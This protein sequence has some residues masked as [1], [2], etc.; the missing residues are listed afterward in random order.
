[1]TDSTLNSKRIAR[2]SIYMA[3]R[4]VFVLGLT[5]Y[6]TRIILRVLGVE[7]YGIYNVVCGFV[8]MLAFLSTSMSNGIQRFYNFEY[9][10]NGIAGATKVYNTAIIIQILLS[11]IIVI[12]A[13]SFGLWYL[14]N[15]MVIP[16]ERFSAA[17]IIFQCSIINFVFML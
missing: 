6:T 3:I 15:K 13:E 7:D 12:L 10:K 5:L 16:I 1:M 9:G 8:S 2:N 11:I 14:Y 17:M 4:M